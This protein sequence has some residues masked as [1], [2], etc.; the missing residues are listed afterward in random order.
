MCPS[1][2]LAVALLLLAGCHTASSRGF[3]GHHRTANHLEALERLRNATFVGPQKLFHHAVRFDIQGRNWPQL[4]HKLYKEPNSTIKVVTLGGSVTVGYKLSNT[5]W[6]EQLVPW[7]QQQ[8]P[9]A[10]F[11]LTNLARRATAATFA[12]LCLVQHVP[13]DADIIIVEYSV[14]GYGGPCQCFT[15]PQVAGYETLLRKLI[16]KAPKAAFMSLAAFMWTTSKGVRTAYHDAGEDQHAVIAKRYAIPFMS[17]RDA[18]Y[19]AM[20]DPANPHG[21]NMSQLLV[22]NVHVG[23]YGA[24]VYAS[25]VA[26]GWRHQVT[27]ILLH[28]SSTGHEH[29]ASQ[30]GQRLPQATRT[31]LQ[32]ASSSYGDPASSQQGPWLPAPI[33]PEAAQERWSTVC[34]NGPTLKEH[35]VDSRGWEFV[36]EGSDAC[37]GCHKY[38]YVAYDAGASITFKVNSAVLS[39]EDKASNSTVQLAVSYLRS[40]QDMGVARLEC[41]SGCTC[42]ARDMSGVHKRQTSE[43]Q[44]ERLTVSA[45]PT[46]LVKFTVLEQTTSGGHKFRVASIAVHKQDNILTFMY[47]PKHE[48]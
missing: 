35:V 38:G 16:T 44:T 6:P 48:R 37:P 19:D 33:N 2:V 42:K 40:F 29:L 47:G 8:Y 21:V 1:T 13:E 5:S 31:L 12:A 20:W 4:V 34:A 24:Q 11:Q 32:L 26:W 17:I 45:H 7:L 10:T 46:C 41:A 14:N 36:D 22:D 28:Q 25:F 30:G 15:A 43:V 3:Q 39:E 18:M 9:S 27:R 23:D